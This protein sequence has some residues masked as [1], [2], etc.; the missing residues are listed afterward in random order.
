MIELINIRKSV[1]LR[2]TL[3]AAIV[4]DN[5]LFITLLILILDYKVATF[6][7]AFVYLSYGTAV[8]RRKG[9]E[10]TECHDIAERAYYL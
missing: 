1:R 7:I 3:V 6:A 5:T 2:F 8:F 4:Q 9:F 10:E